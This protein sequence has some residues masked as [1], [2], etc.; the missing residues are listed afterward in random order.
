MGN[1]IGFHDAVAGIV[2]LGQCV[3]VGCNVSPDVLHLRPFAVNHFPVVVDKRVAIPMRGATQ[4]ATGI[5][6]RLETCKK[7]IALCIPVP[8]D[9]DEPAQVSRDG[10]IGMAVGH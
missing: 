8:L 7:P 5:R 1:D 9:R 2:R 3:R 10:A 4:L 6:R